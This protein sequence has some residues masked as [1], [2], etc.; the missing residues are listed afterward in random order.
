MNTFETLERLLT[1]V[2]FPIATLSTAIAVA[3]LMAPGQVSTGAAASATVL[4]SIASAPPA[5]L[6]DHA[7]GAY[8]PPDNGGPRKT[9]GS[10][11]RWR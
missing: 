2:S 7:I 5:T 9:G 11:T 3:C 1:W 4:S 8:Q 6:V 10:G